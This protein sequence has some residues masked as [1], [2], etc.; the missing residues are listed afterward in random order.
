MTVTIPTKSK[1]NRD[2]ETINPTQEDID[3]YNKMYDTVRMSKKKAWAKKTI[4]KVI[5]TT[6]DVMSTP[7][8]IVNNL[9]SKKGQYKLTDKMMTKA[10]MIGSV[11]GGEK[12]NKAFKTIKGNIQKGNMAGAREY[13]KEQVKKIS[14][15][16]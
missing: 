8:R 4:A 7:A 2:G 10:G 14:S 16:K 12:Y 1:M 6:A 3:T 5:G 11:M 13:I 9:K 15:Q